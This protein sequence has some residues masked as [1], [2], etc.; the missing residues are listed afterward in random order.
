MPGYFT[1]ERKEI[2]Y[3]PLLALKCRCQKGW[4]EQGQLARCWL[5]AFYSRLV[6]LSGLFGCGQA[7][8]VFLF[9]TVF[10]LV[11]FGQDSVACMCSSTKWANWIM[12]ESQGGG[13]KALKW[14]TWW[15]A[16][17]RYHTKEKASLSNTVWQIV[18]LALP[19]HSTSTLTWLM[20]SKP[21]WHTDAEGGHVLL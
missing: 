5:A 9:N 1:L 7:S 15:S 13:L 10:C 17:K 11:A 8:C 6:K 14:N 18:S 20:A 16:F 3:A 21:S 19:C 12:N 2:E 4:W